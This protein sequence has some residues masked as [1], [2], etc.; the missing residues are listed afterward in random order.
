[1]TAVMDFPAIPSIL[2]VMLNDHINADCTNCDS[3]E[4]GI[5][6]SMHRLQLADLSQNKVT[7]TYRKGQTIFSQGNPSFGFYCVNKGKIKLFQL[8]KDGRESII[9]IAGEGDI[10]GHRSLFSNQEFHATAVAI[11]DSDVCFIGK[12]Y[13]M[14][15][16]TKNQ[17]VNMKLIEKL[18][19]EMGLAEKRSSSMF[20]KSVKERL[21]GVLLWLREAFGVD[22]PDG[23]IRLNIIL[24]REEI[25]G[26]IGT[27]NETV[28]R[29]ISELKSER[30]I[31][32]EGRTILIVDV[33]KLRE[34]ANLNY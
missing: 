10:L 19:L 20:Q 33:N 18:S 24:T 32:Q 34:I 31:A 17:S 25:A 13:V 23:R 8:G 1:M 5:F 4:K 6:C 2:L 14:D 29:F 9:R 21:A 3:R 26:M 16:I 28:I 7:N 22:D 15:V 30:I 27:T 11:E 12:K